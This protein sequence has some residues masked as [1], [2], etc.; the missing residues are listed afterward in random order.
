MLNF[1]PE[2]DGNGKEEGVS[3]L[4]KKEKAM[5]DIPMQYQTAYEW[6]GR[7][8]DGNI[9]INERSL[10]A[11]GIP[12]DLDRY[13]PE[14]LLVVAV[15]TCLAN[16]VLLIADMSK[17]LV[18]A[19]RSST[20]GELEKDD[21]GLYRFKRILIRPELTVDLASESLAR[22]VL[23][24][25]HKSCLVARSLSCPVVIEPVVRC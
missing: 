19:Y 15:E 12:T 10:L 9:S 16:Y 24:K 1:A 6:L 13:C 20:E 17:L 2:A 14:H 7:A 11:V 21:R 25:A 23:E 22:R 3:A 8:A 5:V 4:P 18:K